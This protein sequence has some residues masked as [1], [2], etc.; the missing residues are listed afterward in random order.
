VEGNPESVMG[1]QSSYVRAA[2]HAK[3][4]L[5]DIAQG[6]ATRSGA[7]RKSLIERPLLLGHLRGRIVPPLSALLLAYSPAAFAKPD[8]CQ[9][10]GGIAICSSNQSNGIVGGVDFPL[11]STYS[12]IVKDLTSSIFPSSG[13]A[14]QWRLTNSKF[15]VNELFSSPDY[16][17]F[18]FAPTG[19]FAAGVDLESRGSSSGG[20]GRYLGLAVNGSATASGAGGAAV[21]GFVSGNNAS[22]GGGDGDAGADAKSGGTLDMTL[23]PTPADPIA[24]SGALTGLGSGTSGIAEFGKA[25]AGGNGHSG[26]LYSGGNG[27]QGGL[28]GSTY[29]TA[30]GGD[31]TVTS[32]GQNA[33]GVLMQ[34]NGGNG[35]NGG[36]SS[37]TTGGKGGKGGQ[38]G[39]V[40]F[41]ITSGHVTIGTG[42]G[43]PGSPGL[44]LISQAG[45]GGSGG[46]GKFSGDGGDGGAGGGGGPIDMFAP[47]L[48]IT[49]LANSAGSP[50]IAAYS[51][52][53]TGG[54]GGDGGF[55]SG[56]GGRG[57]DTGPSG[58]IDVN[59]Q[60]E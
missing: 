7:A 59:L 25:G 15:N 21:Y 37:F 3:K 53:G 9:I 19:G 41:E 16:S 55:F 14:I 50:G 46:S 17:L 2:D 13:T 58:T 1:A 12:L 22:G 36:N 35:G 57:G 38:G 56:G 5:S 60:G 11:D 52:G 23:G 47:S 18:G 30:T 51:L 32:S 8:A 39:V 6:L 10:A 34:S 27:G 40:K 42:S 44:L 29:L 28:G 31:W 24:N 48:D 33:P 54:R 49:T 20:G 4:S 45:S 26:T 43:D